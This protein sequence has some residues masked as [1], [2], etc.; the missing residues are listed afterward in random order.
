M[1]DDD[2]IISYISEDIEEL[3]NIAKQYGLKYKTWWN[4]LEGTDYSGIIY[5]NVLNNEKEIR[6]STI[7]RFGGI[8]NLK[9]SDYGKLISYYGNFIEN[10][11]LELK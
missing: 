1:T 7:S 5:T 2:G 11:F 3:E 10:D 8:K 4:K 6:E 9:E